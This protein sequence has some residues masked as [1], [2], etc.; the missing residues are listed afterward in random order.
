MTA[1]YSVVFYSDG[2][3]GVVEPTISRFPDGT[4]GVRV[5]EAT[6]AFPD[7][8]LVR[9]QGYEAGLIDILAGIKQVLGR[10]YVSDIKVS[11][12]LPYMPHARYDRFMGEDDA[13][14][15]KLF[16]KQLNALEF[17]EIMVCDPHSS[18]TEALVD[19]I[20]VAEQHVLFNRMVQNRI[21]SVD[22]YDYIVAPDMGAVKKAQKIAD[23]H[24]LPLVVLNKVRDL[25]TGNI[26]GM[27]IL[28]KMFFSIKD[29]L[30]I[31]DDLCDGGRTFIE[32]AKHLK[33]CGAGEVDLY[34]THGIFSQG[35]ENLVDNGIR[36]VY[37]T[38]SFKDIKHEHLAQLEVV[39]NLM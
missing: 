27:E 37:C 17:S 23:R 14:M 16:A 25:K 1:K 11:L 18:V 26:T 9:V 12:A 10:M 5:P 4:I 21:I 8:V 24:N 36:D 22:D 34:V 7:H 38:N 32:T 15:L 29:T 30:L 31:V 28:G 13:H 6:T 3:K 35:V 2:K 19:N 20:V 33:M 39:N